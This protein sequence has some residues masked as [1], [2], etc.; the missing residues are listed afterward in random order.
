MAIDIGIEA[1]DQ[2]YVTTASN[3]FTRVANKMREMEENLALLE[4]QGI[5]LTS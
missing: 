4:G 5:R 3:N 2:K 1:N